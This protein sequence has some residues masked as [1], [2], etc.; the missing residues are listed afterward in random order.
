MNNLEI[1]TLTFIITAVYD[2]IL[3]KVVENLDDFPKIIIDN[4]P[5]LTYLVEYFKKH[6]LLSAALVAGFIGYVAQMII[7]ALHPMPYIVGGSG[8]IEISK[9]LVLTF[10]VSALF[11]FLMKL[12]KL[13]PH[14]D[15]TYY[16]KLGHIRGAYHDGVS[17]LIVQLT[18]LILLYIVKC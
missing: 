18:L 1:Y 7:L 6:T 5:F 16:K 17:G 9:F 14:L 13:F 11:G 10:V 15:D 12:T 8:A 4:F 3:R 2:I